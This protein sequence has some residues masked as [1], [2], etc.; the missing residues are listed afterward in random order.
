MQ[1]KLVTVVLSEKFSKKMEFLAFI[2]LAMGIQN[3]RFRFILYGSY[4]KIR[5]YH[6]NCLVLIFYVTTLEGQLVFSSCKFIFT[7]VVRHSWEHLSN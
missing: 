2:Y 6:N 4:Y 1:G 7:Q 3:L 5:S